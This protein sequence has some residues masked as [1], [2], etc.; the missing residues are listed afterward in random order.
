MTIAPFGVVVKMAPET[1]ADAIPAAQSAAEPTNSRM[2]D[3]IVIV[4]PSL[5]LLLSCC[6][7]LPRDAALGGLVFIVG[8]PRTMPKPAPLLY[9]TKVEA[10]RDGASL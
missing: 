3:V 5:A 4:V 1:C 8:L 7:R 2:A 6:E 10:A 9:S